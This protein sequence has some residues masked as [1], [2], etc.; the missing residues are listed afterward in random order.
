MEAQLE[1][2]GLAWLCEAAAGKYSE[3]ARRL[4]E[5]ISRTQWPMQYPGWRD[6]E[7]LAELFTS[8]VSVALKS[9]ARTLVAI[10]FLKQV[11]PSRS[12]L[13]ALLSADPSA[14]RP[15]SLE[16]VMVRGRPSCE[17]FVSGA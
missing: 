13:Q 7:H 1:S 4:L 3:T 16:F 14:S 17:L 10:N 5:Q 12:V 2:G 9:W 15:T 6:L 11:Q 8:K